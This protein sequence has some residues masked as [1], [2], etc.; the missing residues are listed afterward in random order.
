MRELS[1]GD[2]G[3]DRW[4]GDRERGRGDDRFDEIGDR[5]GD[6]DTG[7]EESDRLGTAMVR[8]SVLRGFVGA[9]DAVSTSFRSDC[10]KLWPSTRAGSLAVTGVTA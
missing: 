6:S 5:L 10:K 7:E 8:F 2:E 4:L 1:G 3:L 9:V